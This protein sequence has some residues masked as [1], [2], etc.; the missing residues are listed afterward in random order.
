M[1]FDYFLPFL[2]GLEAHARLIYID[3]PG[4]GLSER[5]PPTEGYTMEG[6]IAA[7]EG[8]REALGLQTI[9]LLGHS[10]TGDSCPS[11][12]QHAFRIGWRG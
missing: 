6:A 7:I 11:C 10:N 8:L 1:E 3:Q 2:D 5:Q 9:T 4:H 12:M